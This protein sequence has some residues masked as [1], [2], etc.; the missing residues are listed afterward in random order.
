V[1]VNLHPIY[2]LDMRW[3]CMGLLYAHFGL[4][5][6][7]ELVGTHWEEVPM[8]ANKRNLHHS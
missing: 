6:G 3:K 5:L 8:M 4:T 1:E 2:K 7:R